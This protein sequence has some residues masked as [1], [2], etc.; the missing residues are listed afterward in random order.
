MGTAYEYR[1]W[2][3]EG[4]IICGRIEAVSFEDA[5]KQLRRQNL[6]IV[7]INKARQPVLGLFTRK[8]GV[9]ELAVFCRQFAIMSGA[10]LSLPYCLRILIG[11]VRD[12][13]LKRITEEAVNSLE[14]GESITEAF[15]ANSERLPPLLINMLMAAEASGSLDQT[16]ERLADSFEK[17]AALKEKIKSALAYPLLVTAGAFLSVIVLLVY[18]VPVFVEV[19]NQ[20]ET[21]LPAA[22]QILIAISNL[23]RQHWLILLLVFFFVVVLLKVA[24]RT[25]KYR[26]LLDYIWLKLPG[27]GSVATGVVI[28]RFAHTLSLLLK[29]GIPLLESLS[30]VEKTIGNSIAAQEISIAYDLLQKGERFA[31]ALHGSR[32]FPA[33]VIGMLAIGDESGELEQI[34]DKIAHYY[35]QDVEQSI[36][37]LTSLMEPLLITGVGILVGFIALSIYMPLFGLSGAMQ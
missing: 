1:A 15:S 37:R 12:P 13:Q 23:L 34:L 26:L 11:Q 5:V 10:G 19:F 20:A 35:E 14:R 32:I 29:S 28:S 17:E 36:V 21:A 24:Q 4:K 27:F 2:D 3:Q 31:H 16:L 22:T 6:I 33:M 7:K 9:K 18:V 30:V 8:V 25:K